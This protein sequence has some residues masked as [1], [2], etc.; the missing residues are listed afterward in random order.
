MPTAAASTSIRDASR[1]GEGGIRNRLPIHVRS[2]NKAL[3]HAAADEGREDD[4]TWRSLANASGGTVPRDSR[5]EYLCG[6]AKHKIAV[7]CALVKDRTAFT[8]LDELRGVVEELRE[9]LW[10]DEDAAVIEAAERF[11]RR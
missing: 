4:V 6:R 11:A 3:R 2:V 10:I 7:L 9:A 8:E 1:S 5:I